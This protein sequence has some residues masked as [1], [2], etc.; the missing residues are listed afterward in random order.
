MLL[1]SRLAL[2]ICLSGVVMATAHAA[3]HH[4]SHAQHA[5]PATPAVAPAAAGPVQVS[6]PWI[7][8]T[9]K[10]Q[11]GTGGFMRLTS[12]E[13][14]TLVGF[15]STVARTAELH[16]MKME[17]D[18]MRMRPIEGLPL[19]AGQ[20]VELKPGGL[21]LMLLDLKQTL[22][23]GQSVKLTL[24]FKDKDG[25]AFEQVLQVPVNSAQPKPAKAIDHEHMHHKH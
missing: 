18:V 3:D 20:A 13:G 21:H 2:S 4:K 8:A 15:A 23:A 12:P 22:K 24:K 11:T 1:K 14:A 6:D 25:K 9:V 10:G 5:V 16:E 19:P 7:R 17:G